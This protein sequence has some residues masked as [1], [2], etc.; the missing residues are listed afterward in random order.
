MLENLQKTLQNFKNNSLLVQE[1]AVQKTVVCEK[2]WLLNRYCH[3][4]SRKAAV[5][6]PNSD[7][8]F[9][10]KFSIN[11]A[12]KSTGLSPCTNRPVKCEAC[13]NVYWSY[14]MISHYSIDHLSLVV[15]SF[16]ITSVEE[17]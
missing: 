10:D 2:L 5:A 16:L 17:K 7:C 1:G 8:K 13:N 11:C 14:N 6:G 4:R 9:F 3:N 12:K 15:P